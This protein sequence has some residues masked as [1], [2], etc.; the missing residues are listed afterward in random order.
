M[1]LRLFLLYRRQPRAARG[2]LRGRG[3]SFDSP[4][5]GKASGGGIYWA[6]FLVDVC[7]ASS[8]VRYVL[9][10]PAVSV[11]QYV[12]VC[13]CVCACW[14]VGVSVSDAPRSQR[15]NHSLAEVKPTRV[16]RHMARRGIRKEKRKRRADSVKR[17]DTQKKEKQRR[18]E[19]EI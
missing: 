17:K 3:V 11:C 4:K 6:G 15:K 13:V 9:N 5:H 16:T 18:K 7:A 14:C 12:F 2:V 10:V 19:K 8:R 1:H